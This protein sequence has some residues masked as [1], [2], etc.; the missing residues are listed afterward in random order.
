MSSIPRRKFLQQAGLG[1]GGLM[2]GFPA[3]VRGQNLN[4]RIG[5]ACIGVYGKGDSDVNEAAQCGGEIVGLCDV[6]S[7]YLD[8]KGKQFPK[9][10]KFADFREMLDKLDKSID[11]VTISTPDHVH[12]VAA[13]AALQKGKHIFCQKPLTQTVWEARELVRLAKEKKVAT[14]MGNQGSSWDGFRRAVEVLQAGV[15]GNVTELHVWT[16]RPIWPQG[17]DRPQKTDPVPANL[18]WDL[19]LG[20]APERPYVNGAYHAFNWRG[21]ADFGTGA[22]GDMACHLVNMPFHGLKLGYPT[23][24]ECELSSRVYTES[25][26]L[27][28][29]VRFEFPQRDG[30]PPM[31]M[32]WYEGPIKGGFQPLHPDGSL[33]KDTYVDGKLVSNGCMIIGDKGEMFSNDG[34]GREFDLRMKGEKVFTKGQDHEVTKSIPITIPRSKGHQQ[35]WFDAMKG[36][37]PA[38]SNFDVAGYLTEIILLG[39]IAQ[40][41][42]EG[43][44]MK[45]DGPGMTSPNCPQA[46]PFIKPTRRPGW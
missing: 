27:T 19:W 8:L 45:W 2:L 21:W 3:I 17:M 18:N 28:S 46:A 30:L 4:S 32:W 38:Y 25:Y 20:P 15:L 33:M 16:D 40:R 14:Q 42:G 26:P 11:A 23:A 5:V 37:A 6:D 24:V 31:K 36:G 22:L 1:A 12:G 44:N 9:A 10:Q 43:V 13:M 29:R 41:L 39:C 35:E 7:N 34:N